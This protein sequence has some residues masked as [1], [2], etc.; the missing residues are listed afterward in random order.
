MNNNIIEYFNNF[1]IKD[2][3]IS[4]IESHINNFVSAYDLK[5]FFG[6]FDE[7]DEQLIFCLQSKLLNEFLKLKCNDRNNLNNKINILKQRIFL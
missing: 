7:D 2:M 3:R 6:D 5:Y 1:K 4:E